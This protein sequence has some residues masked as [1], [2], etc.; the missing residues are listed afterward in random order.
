MREGSCRE[1]HLLE[2]SAVGNAHGHTGVKG[3]PRICSARPP[4]YS[5]KVYNVSASTSYDITVLCQ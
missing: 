5:D 2:P 3:I 1:E 4:Q